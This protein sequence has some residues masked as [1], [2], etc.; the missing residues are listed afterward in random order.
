MSAGFIVETSLGY[1]IN[2]LL[3]VHLGVVFFQERL[4][5]WQ[6]AAISL[7]AAGVV[8]LTLAHGTLP[9]IALTLAVTFSLYG[10]VKKMA[11]L[12][13]LHG[14]TLETGLVF[15]PMLF[16][17]IF[18]E[19]RGEG[20]VGKQPTLRPGERFRYT[21]AAP[22]AAPSGVM[23]GAYSM[24]RLGDNE[25][26]DIAVPLFALDSPHNAKLVN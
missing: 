3:S 14:L 26:F 7:A 19:V 20:V 9:W 6:W 23:M 10:L 1:F 11:P 17:L 13:A 18:A 16:Y 4:R 21:S 15:A 2:P 22:L 12:G 8:Y 5:L 24:V 25:A